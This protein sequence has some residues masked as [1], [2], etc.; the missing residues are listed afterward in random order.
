[1]HFPP[2]F[3]PFFP[4]KSIVSPFLHAALLLLSLSQVVMAQSSPP[5]IDR[6]PYRILYNTNHEPVGEWPPIGISPPRVDASSLV[7][8][9]CAIDLRIV[10]SGPDLTYQWKKFGVN[11]P[12]ATSSQLYVNVN[13]L[14]DAG[15][16]QCEVKNPYG[17]VLSIPVRMG[18]VDISSANHLVAA[19]PSTFANL[20]VSVRFPTATGGFKYRWYK[21]QGAT[22]DLN[23]DIMLTDGGNY[24]GAAKPILRIK[25]PD[26]TLAGSY[27]CVV[28]AYNTY[29][30]AGQ[31]HLVVVP[32]PLP[33]MVQLGDPMQFSVTPAGP[34]HLLGGLSYVWLKG[35]TPL[36]DSDAS[37]Y[38]IDAATADDAGQYSVSVTHPSISTVTTPPAAG[39][40]ITPTPGPVL[41]AAGG[42]TFLTAPQ[43]PNASQTYRWYR[44][45]EPLNETAKFVGV[46][47]NRLLIRSVQAGDAGDYECRGTLYGNTVVV[48]QPVLIVVPTPSSQVAALGGPLQLEVS[49]QY[50]GS[51]QI[52]PGLFGFQWV[53][54]SGPS[55]T[56]LPD[57]D[58]SQ[59]GVANASLDDSALYTVQVSYPGTTPVKSG[60]V[61][62]CVV[63]TTPKIFNVNAGKAVT[64]MPTYRGAG[65]TFQWRRAG[66]PLVESS[67][68]VGVNR[69]SLRIN[70]VTLA[71][72][73]DDY[74]CVIG[75]PG[76]SSVAAP[77]EV[78][79]YSAPEILDFELPLM[80]VGAS[81]NYAI[82][83]SADPLYAPQS[84]EA[85]TVLPSGSLR[86]LPQGLVINRTTGVISGIPKVSGTFTIRAR[87]RNAVGF[88][89]ADSSLVI[90]PL[91]SYLAGRF[92]G[93]LPRMPAGEFCSLGGRFDMTV[94]TTGAFTGSLLVGTERLSFNGALNLNSNDPVGASVLA[95]V[96][97]TGG[98]LTLAVDLNSNNYLSNGQITGAGNT[99]AF[100]GW[101]S[102]HSVAEPPAEWAGQYNLG[103]LP[104]VPPPDVVDIPKG[105]GF[106][107][108]KLSATPTTDITAGQYT[109]MGFL[110]DGQSI[111]I[112]G[113]VGPAGELL[114]YQPLYT[115]TAVKGSL[116][117][118]GVSLNPALAGRPLTGTVTWSRP[119]NVAPRIYTQGFG[120]VPLTVRGGVYTPGE[121]LLDASEGSLTFADGGITLASRNPNAL[122]S[123]ALGDGKPTRTTATPALT[124]I[125]SVKLSTGAFSGGFSLADDDPTTA[126]VNLREY[127]RAVPFKGL[128]VPMD[129]E[130]VGVGYFLL[131][132]IPTVSPA[133][134]KTNSPILSGSVQFEAVL[135]PP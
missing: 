40:V 55:A 45:G 132:Q 133:T 62:V 50:G 48:A 120:P 49:P 78:V 1:M 5:V 65:T 7:N 125:S 12:G 15:R 130:W 109:M 75:Y 118:N 99:V 64:L 131:P 81:V 36:P 86:P 95:V 73:G 74:D 89:T 90:Q 100:T 113:Y 14:L 30:L 98:N 32:A 134:T 17:T 61:R 102:V 67:H 9:G 70:A 56:V 129:G 38:S 22:P 115:S 114:I 106:A 18:V 13:S 126:T 11:I 24:S 60:L 51:S 63:N 53:K 104:A 108:F 54:G 88:T 119:E 47:R 42:L 105:S 25:V 83:C 10:A 87:V 52:T 79:V 35:G 8:I 33:T 59:W 107:S 41:A 93:H 111:F 110:P 34:A 123:I 135:P 94:A 112:T 66:V 19:S 91:P 128:V 124:T 16:Y 27:Y 82:A 117:G 3:Q 43:P 69:L 76:G 68:H 127:P 44:N 116:L 85:S 46:T 28:T 31:R 37:S 103:L 57:G 58:G 72:A 84:F 71:D 97:R 20:S 122:F 21:Q 23:N 77:M 92:T 121:R 29:M 2:K 6:Q 80:T 26:T 39:L 96:P 101:R 4:V